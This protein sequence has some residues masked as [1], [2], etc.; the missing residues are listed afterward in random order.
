MDDYIL[1]LKKPSFQKGETPE[2]LKKYEGQISEA[3]KRCKGK[4]G[5]EYRACLIREA[6]KILGEEP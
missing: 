6:K 4:K 2:H 1:L 5:A 3:P